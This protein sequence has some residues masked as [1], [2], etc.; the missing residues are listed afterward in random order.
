MSE[1]VIYIDA[2]T[3]ILYENNSF[4]SNKGVEVERLNELVKNTSVKPLMGKGVVLHTDAIFVLS[5]EKEDSERLLKELQSLTF[6]NGA[7]I[8][9][10]AEEPYDD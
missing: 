3:Q 4:K 5:V 9:A 7:Y 8:K 2:N 10:Q 6:I 1:I